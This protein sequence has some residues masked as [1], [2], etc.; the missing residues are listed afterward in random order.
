MNNSHIIIQQNK[1][2]CPRFVSKNTVTDK[3]L[4]IPRIMIPIGATILPIKFKTQIIHTFFLLARLL[5]LMIKLD[6]SINY[7]KNIII[8][9]ENDITYLNKKESGQIGSNAPNTRQLSTTTNIF[10]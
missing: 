1:F 5:K 2:Q 8:L 10:N 7:R 3:L 6:Y 9:K 4:N